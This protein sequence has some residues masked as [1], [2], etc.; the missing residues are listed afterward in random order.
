MIY[1]KEEDIQKTIEVRPLSEAVNEKLGTHSKYLQTEL[2]DLLDEYCKLSVRDAT[3][4]FILK[5]NEDIKRSLDY[6]C[7]V[8]VKWYFNGEGQITKA[9]VKTHPDCVSVAYGNWFSTWKKTYNVV[10]IH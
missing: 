2:Q 8:D 9:V 6:S 4:E 5:F 1:I 7:P 10:S 3:H